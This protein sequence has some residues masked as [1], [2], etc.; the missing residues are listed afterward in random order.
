MFSR[1]LKVSVVIPAYNAAE[2]LDESISSVLDQ[3]YSNLE[4]IVVDDGSIDK[5]SDIVSKFRDSRLT[6]VYQDNKGVS[7]ARNRGLEIASGDYIA[8]LDADDIWCRTKLEMQVSVLDNNSDIDFIF[9]N[10]LRFSDGGPVLGDLFSLI[11]EI[12]VSDVYELSKDIYALKKESMAVFSKIKMFAT[13]VPTC[14]FRRKVVEKVRFPEGVPISEDFDFMLRVYEGT[15]AAF[16]TSPQVKVRRHPG[17]SFHNHSDT[18]MPDLYA[19]YRVEKDLRTL[20]AKYYL[21]H[22]KSQKWS[23]LAYHYYS[24]GRHLESIYP[25][26]R[27]FLLPGNRVNAFMHLAVASLFGVVEF[28]RQKK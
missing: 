15:R 11:P 26:L 6:Y 24:R 21:L 12:L 2:Y 28:V 17:N 27:C 9:T 18:L 8:F 23:N 10:L 19:A 14:L 20:L 1:G 22:I 16:I 25:Y 4:L 5:T 3:S 7:G 13:W